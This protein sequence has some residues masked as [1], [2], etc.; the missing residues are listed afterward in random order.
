VGSGRGSRLTGSTGALPPRAP[1]LRLSA[2]ERQANHV[3]EPRDGLPQPHRNRALL[4]QAMAISVSVLGSALPNIALPSIAETLH[5]TPAA[6][7]WVVNAYQIAVTVSLLPLSSLG[8]ILGYR[9]ISFWG[10]VLFIAG[11]LACALAPTLGVLAAAR[12]LQGL[13]AAGIMSVNTAL[14]RAIFPHA[15]LG[16][17]MGMNALIVAS[18][19]ALGP[20]VAAGILTV[21]DWPWLFAINV[22]IGLVALALYRIVPT[23][24]RA[25]H[26]FD[27]PSAALNAATFGLFIVG[28]DG[29]GGDQPRLI[30][31]GL[32]AAAVGMGVLFVRRQGRLHAPMLPVDLFANP[33]F[34]LTVATSICSFLAQ[35]SAYVALPF[36]FQSTG[37]GAIDIG[38]LMTPW[39][40][41]VMLVAP[42]SGRLSDRFSAGVLGGLG[43]GL[44]AAGMLALALLPEAPAFWNVAWRMA[45]TGAGFGLFQSP[46]N[47]ALM[48]AVPRERSGAGSG[49]IS[50]SRLLGQ[51]VGAALVAV[52]FH[53]TQAAGVGQG[54]HIVIL[55]AAGFAAVASGISFLRVFK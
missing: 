7:V 18:C 48:S 50:T 8:D 12:V 1:R 44:M 30:A 23:T 4:V 37:S 9:R 41:T 27:L 34:A 25:G 46:N 6:S 28:L 19:T 20:T 33:A 14:I 22:P 38:L 10:L 53:L 5:V 16:R 35:T 15:M 39:P 54:A 45:L 36:L 43:L 26:R 31:L 49:M 11:S 55:M 3:N 52:V 21:A 32:L 47:R 2:L 51:T 29:F 13:G 40:A 17:G 42:I 24:P